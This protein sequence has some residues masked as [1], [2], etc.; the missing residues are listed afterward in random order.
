MYYYTLS[1]KDHTWKIDISNL[2]ICSLQGLLLLFLEKCDD[3]G[4]KN[5]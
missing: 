3:F 5:E 2:S 1:K 4:N